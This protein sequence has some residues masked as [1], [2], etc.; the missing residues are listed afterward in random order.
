MADTPFGSFINAAPQGG[1]IIVAERGEGTG[2]GIN[3]DV[4]NFLRR[5][6]DGAFESFTVSRTNSVSQGATV[7]FRRALDNAIAFTLD[8]DGSG[9]APRLRLYTSF[10]M[11]SLSSAGQAVV[12]QGSVG[13]TFDGMLNVGGR[14]HVRTSAETCLFLWDTV[15]SGD[16]IFALFGTEGVFSSRGSITFNRGSGLTAYNTTSDYRAKIVLGPIEGAG[17]IIDALRPIMGRMK[18]ASDARPMFVAHE[19]QQVAAYAVTGEKDAVDDAGKPVMQQMDASA[20][21]PLII[22]ELK[23]LRARVADL[24]ALDE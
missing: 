1:D 16:S 9:T 10:E 5:V 8:V 17:D 2:V 4:G 15:T 21:I 18:G 13:A 20:L 14:T 24:E 12:G 23:H 3:I 11:F 7:R 19:V 6:E 22:A